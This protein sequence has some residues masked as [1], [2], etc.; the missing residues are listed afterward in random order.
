M[1]RQEK[2][3]KSKNDE[4]ANNRLIT[5]SHVRKSKRRRKSGRFVL[6]R[7]SA[8]VKR[9]KHARLRKNGCVLRRRKDCGE[10]T[11]PIAITAIFKNTDIDFL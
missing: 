9:K 11:I 7:K 6:P 3:Q 5:K 2:T 1:S 10:S 8:N 4:S